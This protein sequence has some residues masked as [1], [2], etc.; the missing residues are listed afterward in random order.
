MERKLKETMGDTLNI[1]EAAEL[2]DISEK[3]LRR[4]LQSGDPAL[5][6]PHRRSGPRGIYKLDKDDV[7]KWKEDQKVSAPEDEKK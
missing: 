1:K 5:L 3:T 4:W 7:I 6:V 2:L